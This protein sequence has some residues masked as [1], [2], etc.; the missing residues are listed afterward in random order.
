MIGLTQ[1]AL[2]VMTVVNY[3]VGAITLATSAFILLQPAPD[4]DSYADGDRWWNGLSEW[5]FQSRPHPSYSNLPLFGVTPDVR[6]KPSHRM[7]GE[8]FHRR[9][10]VEIEVE[11]LKESKA[12]RKEG[13]KDDRVEGCSCIAEWTM[14]KELIVDQWLLHRSGKTEWEFGGIVDLEAPT[15]SENARSFTLKAR[16]PIVGSNRICIEIPDIVPRYQL[17]SVEGRSKKILLK[18][19]SLLLECPHKDD[20]AELVAKVEESLGNKWKPLDI[21]VPVAI[22]LSMAYGATYSVVALCLSYVLLHLYKA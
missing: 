3:V 10:K 22:P 14:P 8:G 7:A 15:Y 12:V 9:Y 6:L 21:Q 19:P 18:P 20:V 1:S 4:A 2:V 16:T 13:E 5:M 17:P 11:V